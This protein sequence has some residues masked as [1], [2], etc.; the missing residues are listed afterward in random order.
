MKK[1]C[2]CLIAFSLSGFE[3]EFFNESDFDYILKCCDCDIEFLNFP[4]KF[5]FYNMDKNLKIQYHSHNILK[6]NQN[7]TH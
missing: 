6:Y 5:Y 2:D 4:N 1:C 3:I 7:L